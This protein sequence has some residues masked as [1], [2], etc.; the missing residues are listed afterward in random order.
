MLFSGLYLRLVVAL[1]VGDGL[2]AVATVCQCERKV[3][4]VPL[5]VGLFFQQLDV[6]IGYGHGQSVVEADSSK[7]MRETQCGHARD[8]F[9]DGDTLGVELV[10]HCVGKGQVS[11]ALLIDTGAEVLVIATREAA[12]SMVS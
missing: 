3:A 12:K 1:G 5:A 4:N 11:D 8:V 7:R 10:Q 9:C 2:F 6:H